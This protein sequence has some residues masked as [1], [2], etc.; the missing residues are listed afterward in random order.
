M[1]FVLVNERMPRG[2]SVCACCGGPLS[3]GYLRAMPANR[4]Y[5]GTH[6]YGRE[7]E[8]GDWSFDPS[9]HLVRSAAGQSGFH[10]DWAAP[11]PRQ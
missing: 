9:G 10:V 7:R 8:T 4:V 11:S 1:R 2:F 3:E 6:C 5:C